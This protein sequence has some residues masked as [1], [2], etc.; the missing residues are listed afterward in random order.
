MLTN[1]NIGVVPFQINDSF[2][3]ISITVRKRIPPYP[4]LSFRKVESRYKSVLDILEHEIVE[5]DLMTV[6]KFRLRNSNAYI[7]IHRQLKSENSLIYK[8]SGEF[9]P[10][11]CAES[12]MFLEETPINSAISGIIS[13][14]R[15]REIINDLNLNILALQRIKFVD[16][17]NTELTGKVIN[18]NMEKIRLLE[19]Q[20]QLLPEIININYFVSRLM[21]SDEM[22]KKGL[23]MLQE[24]IDRQNSIFQNRARRMNKIFDNNAL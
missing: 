7:H 6:Q 13:Y 22:A 3:V 21:S 15:I 16:D 24:Q 9:L 2:S 19:E 12:R 14:W 4:D 20:L 17:T 1:E 8:S 18:D 23:D 10:D 11:D 5:N